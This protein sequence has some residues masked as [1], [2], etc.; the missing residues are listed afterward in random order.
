MV[1][2]AVVMSVVQTLVQKK[3]KIVVVLGGWCDDS[4][5][6]M[7]TMKRS[8]DKHRVHFPTP[9]PSLTLSTPQHFHHPVLSNLN[10]ITVVETEASELANTLGSLWSFAKSVRATVT[11]LS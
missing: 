7:R 11:K 6:A 1:F 8:K 2:V 10:L 3:K 9:P 4:R 5:A